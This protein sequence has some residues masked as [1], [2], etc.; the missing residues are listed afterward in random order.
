MANHWLIIANGEAKVPDLHHWMLNR[1]TIALDGAANALEKNHLFPDIL[2]GDFDSVTPQLPKRWKQMG[3]QCLHQGDQNYTDLEKAIQFAI[4]CEAAD[5]VIL[6][7]LGGRMDHELANIFFLKKYA[8]RGLRMVICDGLQYIECLFD[9][10]RELVAPAGS[11]CGFFGMPRAIISSKGLKYE[12]ENF[13]IC[14]GGNESVAN[15]FTFG[16]AKITVLG[17]CLANYAVT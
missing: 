8:R 14:L 9:E 15:E 4:S 3:V 5:I 12:M 1:Q 11:Y 10:T 6:N 17:A 16:T 7:A 2:M 13:L